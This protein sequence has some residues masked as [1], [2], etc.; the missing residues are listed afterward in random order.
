MAAITME[1]LLKKHASTIKGFSRGQKIDAKVIEIGKKLATFDVGGKSEGVL[2][3]IYFQEARDYV[4]GLKPGDKVTA[5]VMDPETADGNVLLSLRHAAS[6]SLWDRLEELKKNKSV[7]SVVVKNSNSSGIS[8]DFEGI[9]GFV[10]SSQVG[11]ELLKKI[12]GLGGVLHVKVIEVDKNRRK[13]VFSEREVSEAD[14]I[15]ELGETLKKIKVGE[16]YEGVVTTVANFGVFVEI[17]VGKTK[18]EGLVHVSELSWEK[19]GKPSDKVKEGDKVE[20]KVLGVNDGKL[21]LSVKQAQADPWEAAIKKLKVDD[22]VKGKVVRHS[23][24]GVF[25]SI[26]PGVE[27]LIHITKIP[28]ATKLNVGD[29]VN[30]YIEEIDEKNKKISLGI[31]LTAKP[32]AYK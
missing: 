26:M 4:K 18:V 8:V 30:C 24:F 17:K 10:P 15:K 3:D 1:E 25:V 13:I 6:D 23:D 16:V 14:Q 27:G 9:N 22:K 12:D 32:V 31:V 2:R 29:E 11:R 28:P 5:M 21:S 7:V 19:I 20:V